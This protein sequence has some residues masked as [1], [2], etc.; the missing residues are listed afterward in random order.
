MVVGEIVGCMAV[1]M[2]AVGCMVVAP[3]VACVGGKWP[4]EN[5]YAPLRQHAD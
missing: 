5:Q 1:A 3:A 4:W 2:H